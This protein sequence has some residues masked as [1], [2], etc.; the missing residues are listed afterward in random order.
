MVLTEHDTFCVDVK[1]LRYTTFFKY[2]NFR[3]IL[4]QGIP[5]VLLSLL[6][7]VC[8]SGHVLRIPPPVG[9]ISVVPSHTYCKS[10]K[11]LSSF[12]VFSFRDSTRTLTRVSHSHT[13]LSC[14][15]VTEHPS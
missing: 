3:Y 14:M 15:K 5:L 9:V 11:Y 7:L 12:V 8:D 6:E 1:Y 4:S 10:C 2:I 13:G